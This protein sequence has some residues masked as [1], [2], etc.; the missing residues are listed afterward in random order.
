MGYSG[1]I[2]GLLLSLLLTISMNG[3][4]YWRIERVDSLALLLLP[5]FMVIGWGLGRKYDEVKFLSEKDVLT[6]IYNRRFIHDVLP[7]LMA[8]VVRRK[9]TLSLAVVD[10]DNFKL[11]NDS[12]GHEVGDQVLQRLSHILTSQ[13]RTSDIVARWGGDEF[14]IIA[15]FT[16]RE[17]TEAFL[18]RIRE[19]V[20]RLAQDM[21]LMITISIGTSVFPEDGRELR[22]LIRVADQKMYEQKG[23]M[24]KE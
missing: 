1:R 2:L 23:H 3:Y 22:E 8:M 21:E 7:K 6:E 5:V 11:I 4:L 10:V 20:H 13:V 16:D 24:N 18:D 12:Y 17:G 9:E 14:L 19:D 15:P